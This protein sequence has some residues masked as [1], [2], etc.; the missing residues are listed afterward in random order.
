MITQDDVRFHT[1]QDC[2]HDWCETNFF[3]FTV[4]E[5]NLLGMVYLVF[6]AG[7]GAV[8]C[9]VTFID[10]VTSSAHDARYVDV[11]Q[12]LPIPERM[13]SFRLPNGVRVEARSPTHYVVDYEGVDGTEVHVAYEG[14]MEPYDI[15]D[16]EID[17]MAAPDP[18]AAVRGSGFGRAYAS[19]FD[20]T[21]R[22]TG[23]VVV[24]GERHEVDCVTTMDHSWG[25][26][27]ERGMGTVTWINAH[28]DGLALHGIFG[29]EPGEPGREHTFAHGYALVDGELRGGVGGGLRVERGEGILGAAYELSITDVGGTEHRVSGTPAAAH[30][31]YAYSCTPTAL[32]MVDWT[33]PD[34]R[35]GPGISMEAFPLDALTGGRLPYAS[36]L[37][38]PA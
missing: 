8:A 20:L 9:D 31:W 23:H 7:V 34:G 25:P 2:P 18:E 37:R 38:A 15:H 10:R 33:T 4:P 12:H 35:R 32:A 29:F 24:R 17:P 22:A 19:H 1:P 30:V 13:E 14:L 16:P 6:R 26:R 28:V 3:G 21:A 27:P 11:Q 5:A 36:A